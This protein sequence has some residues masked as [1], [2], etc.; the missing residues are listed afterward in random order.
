MTK[1]I[2]LLSKIFACCM[3]FLSSKKYEGDEKNVDFFNSSKSG[4]VIRMEFD[5]RISQYIKHLSI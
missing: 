5:R 3:Q 1:T 2:I 4:R